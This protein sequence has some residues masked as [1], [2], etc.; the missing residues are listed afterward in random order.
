MN[1]ENRC[2]QCGAEL[3]ANAPQGLCPACLLKGA[4]Q[5]QSS[6]TGGGQSAGPSDDVPPTPAELA[7]SFPDLEILEFIGRGGMGMVYKARQKH[8]D[9]PVALKI[10]LP[11]IARDPAFAE[12]FAREARAMA[13]LSHPHIVTVYDFGQ[14]ISP[15]PP[16][17]EGPGVTAAGGDGD[18]Y[19]FLMEFV[20]GA[21]L[22]QLLNAGKLAPPEALAIVPQIC[23]AL[24]YAHDRGVVHRDIKPEN[25]LMDRGGQVKIADF[26]LAKLV[27]PGKG[28]R[29]NLCQAPAGPSGQIGPLPFS[30]AALTG[31]GQVMGT[32]NYMA[33][34]QLEHP[35]QVD[36]RADIYSLGVVFYQMLT[37]ELPIGRFAPPSRKVQIDVRLDEVVLRALE[38]EPERRFQQASE[39][40]TEVESIATTPTPASPAADDAQQ[41]ARQS[42][43]GPAIGLLVTGILNWLA[44]P[45][46]VLVFFAILGNRSAD[47][48]PAVGLV[49]A[50]VLN[51]VFSTLMILG[52]LKMKR[53]EW[54]GL[55]IAAS[56]AALIVTPG[57]L[58]GLPIGIWSLVVLSGADVRAAFARRQCKKAP[59]PA[60][61]AQRRFGTAALVLCVAAFP[62]ALL[63]GI[64]MFAILLF[65]LLQ[66]IALICGIA[67]RRSV[68]GKVGICLSAL[69]LVL[70]TVL[71]AFGLIS[72][73]HHDFGGMPTLERLPSGTSLSPGNR[74]ETTAAPHSASPPISITARDGN[75]VMAT[76]D[77]QLTAERI[78]IGKAGENA[79]PSA[80]TAHHTLA[81]QPPIVVE[82]FP[83]SGA[84]DVV[85]AKT[86]IRVRFSKEMTD[87]SWSWSDAWENSAPEIIGLPRYEADGRTCVAKV[88]L[89]PARTYAFWLN[90]EKFR[91]FKDRDGRAAVP[92]LLI[93]QTKQE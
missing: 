29:S 87:A 69:N 58:I 23:D 90:S 67:G 26:G 6:A 39:V 71:L 85:P 19:Y 83:V 54:H 20:D 43:Q 78:E 36:H 33:P 46:I 35:Q 74:A 63:G 56:V 12:R 42:V 49:P 64:W 14:T 93:F 16:P 59:R 80:E 8:L 47:I 51:L 21:T 52:A 1:A 37:G 44:T 81:G 34:E 72:S 57:N 66:V 25:I 88:K 9:R 61:P 4:L 38:K 5:T 17:G 62:L 75:V 92:Y 70:G 24:Q 45:L 76:P 91:N 82:T 60:T 79:N 31:A 32:P 10:L 84:R 89:E 48:V 68:A 86:E 28:E 53:L 13:M 30:E 3:A 40:K 11:K 41:H 77:S 73:L 27:G 15:L 55:A 22:R 65:A 7:P 18:L 2:P 50:L